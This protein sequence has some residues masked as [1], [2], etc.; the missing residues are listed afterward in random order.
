MS[1]KSIKKSNELKYLQT[2]RQKLV[3]QR[4]ILKKVTKEK[5][6]ELTSLNSKI[7]NIDERLE[8]L[9]SGNEIIFSEHAILR[10]IERVLGINLTDIKA[11]I[12]TESEKDE[13]MQMGGNLTYKKE[14]FTVKIQDFVV[15]T[16]FKE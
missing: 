5:Q 13:C 10:Y 2:Q 14:D 6:D 12:L 8:K 1:N 9:I 4:E 7:K 3:S 11:K 16:V 15:T